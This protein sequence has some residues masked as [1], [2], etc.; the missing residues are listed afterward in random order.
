MSI[1]GQLGAN[2]FPIL[3]GQLLEDNPMI[4]M[5]LTA[6]TI[7][8]YSILFFVTVFIGKKVDSVEETTITKT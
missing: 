4:L 7:F 8:L 5:Y 2:V 6:T 3:S 1:A